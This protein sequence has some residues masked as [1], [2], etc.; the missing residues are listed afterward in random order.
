MPDDFVVAKSADRHAVFNEVGDYR[1]MFVI[2]RLLSL[3]HGRHL[4]EHAEARAE[5]CEFIVGQ[6]LSAY[7][8]DEV[9]QPRAVQRCEGRFVEVAQVHAGHKCTERV[10]NRLNSDVRPSTT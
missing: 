8:D 7:H 2:A 4:V 1:H 3:A 10:R 5:S 9:F 6:I